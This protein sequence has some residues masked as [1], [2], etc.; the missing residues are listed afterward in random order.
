[1]SVV[2]YV[3][4]GIGAT[5]RDSKL[6][7][8][9]TAKYKRKTGFAYQAGLGMGYEVA[10]GIMLD[11]GYRYTG[12]SLKLKDKTGNFKKLTLKGTHSFLAGVRVSF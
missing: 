5:S 2:P 10:S 12:T 11:A 8:A 7:G 4:A 9:N 3:T 1:M 6:S